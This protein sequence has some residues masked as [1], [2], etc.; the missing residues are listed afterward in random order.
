MTVEMNLPLKIHLHFIWDKEKQPPFL[1]TVLL[2]FVI[3]SRFRML[4][5]S[6][7]LKHQNQV[8]QSFQIRLSSHLLW[9][10]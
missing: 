9:N 4:W 10:R 3:R 8:F 2:D 7:L 5:R 6:L 1:K